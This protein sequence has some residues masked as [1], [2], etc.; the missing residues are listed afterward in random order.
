M[1]FLT[2]LLSLLGAV[3]CSQAPLD[4]PFIPVYQPDMPA[5]NVIA[6][7][8]LLAFTLPDMTYAAYPAGTEPEALSKSY[9]LSLVQH[10]QQGASD[11]EQLQDDFVMCVDILSGELKGKSLFE[12]FFEMQKLIDSTVKESVIGS[13][14]TVSRDLDS[15]T[16]A[17]RKDDMPYMLTKT[18]S[19]Q[20]TDALSAQRTI[21]VN[22]EVYAL[23]GL[24]GEWIRGSV[25]DGGNEL[26]TVALDDVSKAAAIQFNY[27]QIV[28]EDFEA[29]IKTLPAKTSFD[30]LVYVSRSMLHMWHLPAFTGSG[31]RSTTTPAIQPTIN[32]PT[33]VSTKFLPLVMAK[34]LSLVAAALRLL[35]F[36]VPPLGN[37]KFI[38]ND[39]SERKAGELLFLLV[40]S[41]Q[42]GNQAAH[43]IDI[44]ALER[45][46]NPKVKASVVKM[47]IELRRLLSSTLDQHRLDTH[48]LTFHRVIEARCKY[49]RMNKTYTY[50]TLT[51][52]F[53]PKRQNVYRP[54]NGTTVRRPCANVECQERVLGSG[55]TLVTEY[56]G[57]PR[58]I[59]VQVPRNLAGKVTLTDLDF[60]GET[61]KLKAILVNQKKGLFEETLHG[62]VLLENGG[63]SIQMPGC[64][65]SG[66]I[67]LQ[68]LADLQLI[69][70]LLIYELEDSNLI[71]FQF[72][73][74]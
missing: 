67:A 2:L 66:Q 56:I 57:R 70:E 36:T 13:W 51:L 62:V 71:P 17:T 31:Q 6:S 63:L 1:V 33:I 50:S 15:I 42:L 59:S 64:L 73:L 39:D 26:I 45:M 21:T 32:T 14:I 65:Y 37:S 47:Y 30:V 10:F 44:S 18:F 27:Q 16:P 25:F 68:T 12:V 48:S 43:Q 23:K 52:D 5:R 24:L 40:K 11:D 3:S 19:S 7:A 58:Q 61:Y 34:P 9:V 69:P 20:H 60:Y 74:Q 41:I 38:A 72:N 49:C 29:T 54:G 53:D 35:T 22:G 46:L 55:L 8:R 4:F 28:T